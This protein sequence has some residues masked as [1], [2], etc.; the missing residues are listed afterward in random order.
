MNEKIDKMIVDIEKSKFTL[1]KLLLQEGKIVDIIE[2]ASYD[3]DYTYD[4]ISYVSVRMNNGDMYKITSQGY[5]DGSLLDYSDTKDE[6]YLKYDEWAK[7][8]IDNMY[9]EKIRVCENSP[10]DYSIIDNFD[11][12]NV[13]GR[14]ELVKHLLNN[15]DSIELCVDENLGN[16]FIYLEVKTDKEP[17]VF[18]IKSNYMKISELFMHPKDL[19]LENKEVYEW[20][21]N[22]YKIEE[23]C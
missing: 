17:I 22:L 23:G 13:E 16:S 20:V 10:I 3:L 15:S 1:L 6:K 7:D 12:L 18:R 21:N 14:F 2:L 4:N 9:I 19:F 5:L 11:K 8:F